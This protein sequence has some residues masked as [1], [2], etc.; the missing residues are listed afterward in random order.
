M[1]RNTYRLPTTASL[2]AGAVRPH[3]MR[4]GVTPDTTTSKHLDTREQPMQLRKAIVLGA[5]AVAAGVLGLTPAVQAT[6]ITGGN[7][8]TIQIGGS[9][10]SGAVFVAGVLKSGTAT[11]DALG[12][13]ASC[14]SGTIGGVA[15]RG[16]VTSGGNVF[17]FTTLSMTCNTPLGINATISLN[18]SC[19]VA[20]GL[21]GVRPTHD[22]VHAGL[23]DTGLYTGVTQKNHNVLGTATIPAGN[24]VK[25]QLTSGGCI[26]YAW[27]T[28]GVQFD[29]AQKTVGGVTYQDLILKG[30]STVILYNANGSCLGLMQGSVSLNNIDFNVQVGSGAM[31][32]RP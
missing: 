10:A 31:D 29:E 22:N 18:T 5:A 7:I 17:T 24:C 21:G 19:L 27:G 32:F 26:A 28:T 16:P 3:M 9:S 20:V 6:T 14:A 1:E 11:F 30:T 12:F 25:V 8:T 4:L 23:T 15:N 13:T 2:A